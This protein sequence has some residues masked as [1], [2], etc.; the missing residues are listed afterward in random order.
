VAT[1]DAARAG[2]A[3]VSNIDD[4]YLPDARRA[5]LTGR[6]HHWTSSEARSASRTRA[7]TATPAQ[8]RL[9]AEQVLFVGDSP[10]QD[11]AGARAR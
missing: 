8:G 5:G 10:E 4:D 3:V 2:V 6:L 7:S 11:I 9:R 1:L